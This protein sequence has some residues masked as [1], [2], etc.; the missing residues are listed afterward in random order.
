MFA[1][2]P[3]Q[4]VSEMDYIFGDAGMW[5]THGWHMTGMC[6]RTQCS[7]DIL[8]ANSKNVPENFQPYDISSTTT[9]TLFPYPILPAQQLRVDTPEQLYKRPGCHDNTL[10]SIAL[11]AGQVL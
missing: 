9:C 2:T 11:V 7:N 10:V 3:L 1:D 4:H 8:L 5:L 6:A